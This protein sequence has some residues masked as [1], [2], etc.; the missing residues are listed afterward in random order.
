MRYKIIITKDRKQYRLIKTLLKKS[1]AIDCYR[2]LIH[3]NSKV[4]FEK[5]YVN[6]ALCTFHIELLSPTKFSDV[7]EWEKDSLG[8]NVEAPYRNGLHIWRLKDWK[9]PELFRIYG[10]PDRYDYNFLYDSLKKTK[11]IIGMSTI[12]NILILDIDGKPLLI[13]LKNVSDAIRLYHVILSENMSH[14]LPFGIMSK[15]NRKGFYKMIK[16]MG[17][18]VRMFYTKSTR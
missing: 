1:N 5:K 4:K 2:N 17:I 14:I 11:E 18:P 15:E 10:R 16:S 6:Y 8:R 12:Q 13:I 3:D 7:I 9:E